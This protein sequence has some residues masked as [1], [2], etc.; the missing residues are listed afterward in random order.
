MSGRSLRFVL[1]LSGMFALRC[2]AAVYHSN[3]TAANIQQIHD[4]QAVDGDTITLPAGTFS[5]T[6]SPGIT[7]AITLQGATTVSGAGGANPTVND[8]TIVKD[9]VPRNST[10]LDVAVSGNRVFRLTGITFVPGAIQGSGNT[11]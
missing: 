8:V 9:D 7:K 10:I 11:D 5:W 6:S 3:G 1:I 4:T 2:G